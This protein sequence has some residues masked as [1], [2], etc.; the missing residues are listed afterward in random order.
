MRVPLLGLVG[1]SVRRDSNFSK[2]HR[3]EREIVEPGGR[4]I[5]APPRHRSPG[6]GRMR[7]LAA[8]DR[9]YSP[10]ACFCPMIEG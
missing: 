4:R 5:T 7:A 6:Q 3:H 1:R 10:A 2:R 9:A 8:S